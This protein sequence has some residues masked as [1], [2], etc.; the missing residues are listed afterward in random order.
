M[1]LGFDGPRVFHDRVRFPAA[2]LVPPG[3]IDLQGRSVVVMPIIF[4]AET[5]GFGVFACGSSHGLVYEQLREV[6]GTVV[7]G[8]LLARELRRQRSP[9]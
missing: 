8:G 4:G 6:F 7:K 5:L 2:A 9:G 3:T 1:I